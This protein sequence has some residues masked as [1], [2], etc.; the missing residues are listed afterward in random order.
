MKTS[1]SGILIVDD[2][3]VKHRISCRCQN[4]DFKRKFV[5][6]LLSE[7]NVLPTE[8][9]VTLL[10]EVLAENQRLISKLKESNDNFDIASEFVDDQSHIID[11]ARQLVEVLLDALCG[12]A[13]VDID[14]C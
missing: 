4:G 11:T 12:E 3:G 2:L 9:V 5:M 1:V 8:G 7:A 6:K 13:D 10:G 14:E